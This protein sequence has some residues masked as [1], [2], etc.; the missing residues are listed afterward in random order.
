L[1]YYDGLPGEELRITPPRGSG[2]S[3][4]AAAAARGLEAGVGGRG[5]LR[6]VDF[7][8]QPHPGVPTDMQPQLCVMLALARGASTVRET[9]FENRFSHIPELAKMGCDV[10]LVPGAGLYMLNPVDP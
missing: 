5:V 9:V 1:S 8:T 10:R 6:S 2:A 4:A 3:G 7:T